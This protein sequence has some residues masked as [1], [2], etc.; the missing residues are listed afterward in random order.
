[1][2]GKRLKGIAVIVLSLAC[3]VCPRGGGVADEASRA[4]REHVQALGDEDRD[5]RVRAAAELG[6]LGAAAEEAV[7]I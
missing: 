6:K 5:V 7:K 4:V 3:V 2:S 1:M